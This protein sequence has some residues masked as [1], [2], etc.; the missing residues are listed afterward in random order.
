M[1]AALLLLAAGSICFSTSCSLTK[2]SAV[3]SWERALASPCVLMPSDADLFCLHSCSMESGLSYKDLP[4]CTITELPPDAP[5]P[6]CHVP[7]TTASPHERAPSYSPPEQDTYRQQQ[8]QQAAKARRIEEAQA[9]ASRAQE[10]ARADTR[11]AKKALALAQHQKEVDRQQEQQ[12]MQILQER[13]A[14]LEKRKLQAMEDRLQQERMEEQ[15]RK[16][17]AK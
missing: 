3:D 9:A 4:P 1:T 13:A 11:A 6:A 10:Q 17:A 8:Q 14:M 15:Q 7:L 2:T 5:V 12:R 16:A